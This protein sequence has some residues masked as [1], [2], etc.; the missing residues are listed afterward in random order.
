MK[1]L[2][3]ILLALLMVFSMV[4]VQILAAETVPEGIETL[5]TEAEKLPA[6]ESAATEVVAV[7][8]ASVSEE[9]PETTSEEAEEVTGESTQAT[10]ESILPDV[11]EL[12]AETTADVTADTTIQAAED[13]EPQELTV[14]DEAMNAEDVT[15]GTCGE[16]LTWS[17]EEGVLTISGTGTMTDYGSFT[18]APWRRKNVEKVILENGV[19]YISENAFSGCETLK[20]I[21]I[22]DS[23]EGIGSYAFNGCDA[24]EVI[25]IPANVTD[26]G[27]PVFWG[28]SGLKEIRVDSDNPSYSSDASGV[29]FDKAQTELLKAPVKLTGTYELPDSVRVIAYYAF[30]NCSELSSVILPHGLE[31]IARCAFTG[32]SK[33][34]SIDFPSTLTAIGASAF[35]SSGLSS[36]TIPAS[37]ELIGKYA[38]STKTM[39]SIW[40]AEDNAYY[41]SDAHG[42]LLNK[43]QTTL[44]TVPYGITGEY[45]VSDTVTRIGDSAFNGYAT[46]SRIHIPA[47]VTVLGEDPFPAAGS[48]YMTIIFYGDAP[49][50]TT[51]FDSYGNENITIQYPADNDTWTGDIREAFGAGLNWLP[52]NTS[53]ETSGTCGK[54][55]TWSLEDGV[56]TISGTGAMDSWDGVST[57]APW[58]SFGD[59]I[60][61]VK[62]GENVTT[63]GDRAFALTNV[64]AIYFSGNAPTIGSNIISTIYDDF[65]LVCY[66]PA[67]KDGWDAVISQ[68]PAFKWIPIGSSMDKTL[69][70]IVDNRENMTPE[71]IRNAVQALDQAVLLSGMQAGN[72]SS[73]IYN[74]DL[75]AGAYPELII[76]NQVSGMSFLDHFWSSVTGANLN[77]YTTD[78]SPRRMLLE[79]PSVDAD[80]PSGYDTE[81]LIHFH[82]T[83]ED[84]KNPASYDVPVLVDLTL[85]DGLNPFFLDVFVLNETTGSWEI[86]PCRVVWSKVGFNLQFVLTGDGEYMIAH[87]LNGSV[88]GKCGNNLTWTYDDGGTLTISG[89]GDMYDYGRTS[90]V[91]PWHYYREEVYNIL[92]GEQ[93]TSIG[94][95]AFH[96]CRF[97]NDIRIPAAVNKIGEGAFCSIHDLNLKFN[98]TAPSIHPNAFVNMS[99]DIYYPGDDASW[100]NTTSGT[101]G[102]D[103]YS[104]AWIP[105]GTSGTC[106]ES[107]FWAFDEATGTLTISGTGRIPDYCGYD[108][109]TPWAAFNSDIQ[110]I[111]IEEGITEIGGFAFC[112]CSNLMEIHLPDSLTFISDAAINCSKMD[113]ITIPA[114]VTDISFMSGIASAGK[115]LVD[116]NNPV[117][118][119]LDGVLYSK[120]KTKVLLCPDRRAGNYTVPEGVATI[121]DY[122]FSGCNRL[123]QI[124]LPNTLKTIG[125]WAFNYCIGLK[126]LT[127]PDSV[128]HIGQFALSCP[129]ITRIII[130]NS[131]KTIGNGAFEGCYSLREVIFTGDAP[132]MPE[133]IFADLEMTVCYPAGNATWTDD[134]ML[135]SGGTITWKATIASVPMHRMYDPNSGE[136]FYTGAE[137]ERDFL[138]EA[139]WSYEGVGFNFPVEGP[140]VYRLYDPV[141]GEHLYTMDMT[142]VQMLMDAGWSNEGVAFN[143]AGTDEVPQY[144]LRN[145]NAK[146][147]G[148][149][150]TGSEVERDILID[151]GWIHQ[152][153]GWYS[154]TE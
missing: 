43:D 137:L 76:S 102:A 31:T 75:A 29:F 85:N 121:G 126:E 8:L 91:S 119:S 129:N 98:G 151:A 78:S 62:I 48:E 134:V 93:V 45:T 65:V 112:D 147:G 77:S 44:I 144:R 50:I 72:Y 22:P 136:H 125:S 5:A 108:E 87:R 74:L 141:Y 117:Y 33:L 122:A 150:F 13:S 149:H 101:Y 115:I 138:L 106:S 14:T 21:E 63:V 47:S 148:Y 42:V 51:V 94:N 38:F 103:D 118:T 66:Y 70:D 12:T 109:A 113:S 67:S 54:N 23:V 32:C 7:T 27:D 128:T 18:D 140:P 123:T 99:A 111:V 83:L 82:A 61:S 84:V 60:R 39:E 92:I 89:S 1:R 49:Q 116:S 58:T 71:E 143:S 35:S 97:T 30:D 154:C 57:F 4:P 19:T 135:S 59:L 34:E 17:L 100:L 24:L 25:E 2:I 152:G 11:Q 132:E 73:E 36:V 53:A 3:A 105:Y 133:D 95:Y 107:V 88:S 104:L 139:G 120:D 80:V 142:E 46:L 86:I 153:I 28:C 81:N 40:V 124:N 55:L 37:V 20:A 131:V 41:S 16:N 114:G 69:Q 79:G 90:N 68:N 6:G 130:G 15:S 26:I 56:L 145:P 52:L 146:R 64:E 110:K 10:L 127:I 9:T 96:D